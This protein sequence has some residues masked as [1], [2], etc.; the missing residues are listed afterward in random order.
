MIRAYR[1]GGWRLAVSRLV[2]VRFVH[3][4]ENGLAVY[5]QWR[6]AVFGVRTPS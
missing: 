3:R 4:W 1:I 6:S 2:P 5:W